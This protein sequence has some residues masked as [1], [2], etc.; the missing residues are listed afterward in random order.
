MR[1]LIDELRNRQV[2]RAGAIYIG[3]CWLLI[4][5]A[6][7]ALPIIQAPDHYLT[8]AIVI[9][10]CGLPVTLILSWFVGPVNA[11]SQDSKPTNTTSFSDVTVISLL[12]AASAYPSISTSAIIPP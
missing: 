2:L 5:I 7:I 8:V 3:A 11:P 10:A 12:V 9:A 1:Q 4:G 6:D